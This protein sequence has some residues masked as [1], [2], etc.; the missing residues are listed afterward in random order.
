MASVDGLRNRGIALTLGA[1]LLWSTSFAATGI[2]LRY[3]DPYTLVFLRFEV[4]G[5][6]LGAFL[7]LSARGPAV[8]T[9][10]AQPKVWVLAAVYAAAFVLQYLGQSMTSASAATVISNLFPIIVPLLA[11]FVLRERAGIAQAVA[12]GLGLG[13]LL[14]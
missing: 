4:A 8:R 1:S 3:T 11:Y 13:G 6:A 12:L 7:L 14:L 10:L 9:I 2:G 5:A